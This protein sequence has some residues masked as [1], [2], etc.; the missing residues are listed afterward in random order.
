M[1]SPKTG[2]RLKADL[3]SLTPLNVLYQMGELNVI[4][5]IEQP[6]GFYHLSSFRCSDLGCWVYYENTLPRP[7]RSE[8]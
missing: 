6:L 7:P 5:D 3:D 1:R 2:Q 8:H 4:S